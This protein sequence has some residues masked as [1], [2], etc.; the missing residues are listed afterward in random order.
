MLHS[1]LTE[2]LFPEIYSFITKKKSFWAYLT[3]FL[4]LLLFLLITS[5]RQPMLLAAQLRLEK[6]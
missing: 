4:S 6:G 3:N 2:L 5:G 1:S